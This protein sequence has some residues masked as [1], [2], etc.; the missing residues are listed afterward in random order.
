MRN[1]LPWIAALA[2]AGCGG[3]TPSVDGADPCAPPVQ[4]PDRWLSDQEI[5]LLWGRDRRALLNCRDK[6]ETLSGRTPP[7]PKNP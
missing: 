4:I 3:L 1:P 5:E 7:A 6:V 2:L